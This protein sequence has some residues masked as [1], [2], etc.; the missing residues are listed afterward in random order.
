MFQLSK[1][2]A[3]LRPLVMCMAVA[4]VL[5]FFAF[6]VPIGNFWVKITLSMLCLA[7]LAVLFGGW[8][9]PIKELNRRAVLWGVLSA[10][11]LYGVF[12]V[13][14]AVSNLLFPFAETQV[15][16]IY[17]KGNHTPGWVIALVLFFVTSPAEEIFWRGLLQRRLSRHLGGFGGWIMAAVLYAAVHIS[18]LNFMLVG[19]AGIAGLFW[20]F[21]YWRLKTLWP[22]VISHAVWAG[23]A[24]A[25]AP[26]H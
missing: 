2:N 10:L 1:N 7:F 23:L 8:P 9:L 6:F 13:G 18:S 11:F 16:A 24:F 17:A 22:V 25:V 21:L 4:T 5:W 12:M 19:A 3:D 20:G 15:D 14:N 26:I